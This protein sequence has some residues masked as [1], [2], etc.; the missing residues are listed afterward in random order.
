LKLQARFLESAAVLAYCVFLAQPTFTTC[1]T[2]RNLD[3]LILRFHAGLGAVAP[4][5]DAREIGETT[6]SSFD[7][8]NLLGWV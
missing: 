5:M 1:G 6:P 7:A 3:Q 4:G 8:T 2:K